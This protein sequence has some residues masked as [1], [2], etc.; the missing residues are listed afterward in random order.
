MQKIVKASWEELCVNNRF[1][2][3]K[4]DHLRTC[5]IACDEELLGT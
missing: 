2:A 3:L 4:I 5:F 1:T